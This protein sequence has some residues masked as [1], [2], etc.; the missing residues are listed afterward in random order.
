M[1][2]HFII[3]FE[4]GEAERIPLVELPV[5]T[6]LSYH[7]NLETPENLVNIYARLK[8]SK[9]NIIKLV[10]RAK[11]YGDSLEML[12]VVQ[13][14]QESKNPKE[15]IAF[16]TGSY[17]SITRVLSPLVGAAYTLACLGNKQTANGQLD[18]STTALA[19][20]AARG[21]GFDNPIKMDVDELADAA[22]RLNVDAYTLGQN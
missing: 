21:M 4:L 8:N 10:T 22:K 14:H 19:M 17:G 15:L 3:D 12:R 1:K 20:R 6:L 5:K 9:A 18:F 7:N 2:G 13:E 16:C 11:D